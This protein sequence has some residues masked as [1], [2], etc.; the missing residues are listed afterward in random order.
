M[1]IENS[2]KRANC[3]TLRVPE[4]FSAK[5]ANLPHPAG[6]RTIF[7]KTGELPHP[8]G[9]RAIFC[10]TGEL[11]HPAGARAI[12][13]KTAKHVQHLT[14]RLHSRRTRWRPRVRPHWLR[15]TVGPKLPD[16]VRLRHRL[17]VLQPSWTAIWAHDAR[18]P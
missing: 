5:R 13:C 18:T 16:F 12:F 4:Q 10:K 3:R 6:A 11:P 17:P 9:A 1:L 14:N 8:A 15:Q 7:C 2:A